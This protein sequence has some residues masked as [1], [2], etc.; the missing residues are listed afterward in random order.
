MVSGR[1]L[2]LAIAL[3]SPLLL[4]AQANSISFSFTIPQSTSD[5][6]T[7][8]AVLDSNQVIVKTLWGN[9]IYPPGTYS[10]F[11]DGTY[12][13][14]TSTPGA[15]YTVK[16]MTNQVSY[17]YDGHFGSTDSQWYFPQKWEQS[18]GWIPGFSKLTFVG[19]VGWMACAYNE[20][21]ANIM[22]YPKATPNYP[23]VPN[24][25]YYNAGNH[26]TADIAT[27]G[28][29]VY[30]MES[31]DGTSG[32]LVHNFI[33]AVDAGTASPAFFSQ[34]TYDNT[35]VWQ[36]TTDLTATYID[37]VDNPST[38]VQTGIAVQQ[39]GNILAVAHGVTG[40]IK[41]FNK[42]SGASLG[43]VPSVHIPTITLNFT[44]MAFT[45]EGLWYVSDGALYLITGL[46]GSPVITQPIAGP[47]FSY[48]AAIGSNPTTNGLYVADG[49]T[50][51]QIYE[52]A[53]ST[54]S[55]IRTLGVAG[56]YND[57]NPTITHTRLMLDDSATLGTNGLGTYPNF[58]Y[59][60]VQA[61]ADDDLWVEDMQGRRVQHFDK[62]NAYVNQILNYRPSYYPAVSET[63]PNRL[64]IG[65]LEYTINYGVPNLP[66]D[67]DPAVGGNGSWV[68]SKDWQVCALGAHGSPSLPNNTQDSYSFQSVEQLSNG[69]A[70]AQLFTHSGAFRNIFE[71]PTNGTSP[72]RNTGKIVTGNFLLTRTGD[73]NSWTVSGSSPSKLASIV[74][75]PLTGFDGSNNPINGAQQT[76]VSATTTASNVLLIP[77][78]GGGQAKFSEGTTN[79]YYPIL[80]S[81]NIGIIGYPH[82]AAI[83]SGFSSYAWTTMPEANLVVP[84]YKGS[85]PSAAIT[86]GLSIVRTEGTNIFYQYSGNYTAYGAQMYHYYED[87][88]MIG[89]FGNVAA[90]PKGPGYPLRPTTVGNNQ[91]MSTTQVGSDVYLYNGDEA[92][93]P[94]HRWHISNLG[95]IHEYAGSTILQPSG[96]VT[97]SKVF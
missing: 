12:D 80:Y 6:R 34:G 90:F 31:Q 92:Y 15:S 74:T 62:N 24:A 52:Y 97:L 42:R 93:A 48:V 27:D 78:L 56:G 8:A 38:D 32:T 17:T 53:V 2:A 13:S 49:G 89:Q 77:A 69:R 43:T 20:G 19:N 45:S 46:P 71:L 66:G 86:S 63:M 67:P 29:W 88:M 30:M 40:V 1:L 5:T 26:Y 58:H 60:F 70:Y 76:I 37:L 4:G 94:A 9:V 87:G 96:S 14:G 7:S 10:G 25:A 28:T 36:G 18:C 84:D 65:M 54:H 95:S 72:A 16:F 22:T 41:L 21:S 50:N 35:F 59:V 73:W 55:L 68:L 64:F 33:T 85:Y 79:G 81:T 23:S 51:Q 61:D 83:K 44:P 39:S 3:F 11:W 47:P 57:C 75:Q 91:F 82:A